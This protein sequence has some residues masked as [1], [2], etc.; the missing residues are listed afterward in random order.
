MDISDTFRHVP[1][2]FQCLSDGVRY[3]MKQEGPQIWNYIDDFLCVAVPSK[4]QHSYSCLQ[5]LLHELG[6]TVSKKKLVPPGTPKV[7]CL[8]IL[9][10][11]EDCSVFITPEKLTVIKQLRLQW[12]TKTSCSK[13]E[14][15]SLLGSLLYVAK[16]IK[17]TRFFLN[18][19]FTLLREYYFQNK[20]KLNQEF[21][22]DLKWF[23]TFLSVYNGISFFQYPYT[24]VVHSDACTTSLGAIYNGQV[25]ALQVPESWCQCN[26][27]HLEMINI[28][29]ALKV[30]HKLWAGQNFN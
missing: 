16:C 1:I 22:R 11:T 7:V 23:N 2:G 14:L 12:S 15:Q 13:K 24:K 29:V 3:I 5:N 6:L 28:L 25:Y 8:G 10:N 20:I 19:M 18:R 21:H 9:V 30:W 26:I 4:I 27:A 17:Y